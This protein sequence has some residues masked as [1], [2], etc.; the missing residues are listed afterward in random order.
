MLKLFR[1]R[2]QIFDVN[3]NKISSTATSGIIHQCNFDHVIKATDKDNKHDELYK[4]IGQPIV[5]LTFKGYNTCLFAY[6]PV[7]KHLV[8][9]EQAKT[10]Y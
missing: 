3:E 5:N 10:Y 6:G 7:S 2:D 8:T 4:A 1:D 9:R